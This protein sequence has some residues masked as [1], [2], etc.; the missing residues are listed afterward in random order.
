MILTFAQWNMKFCCHSWCLVPRPS[1]GW[2]VIQ[3]CKNISRWQFS[4]KIHVQNGFDIDGLCLHGLCILSVLYSMFIYSYSQEW[5][6]KSGFTVVYCINC[7]SRNIIWDQNCLD[8]SRSYLEQWS[9][10]RHSIAIADPF[11]IVWSLRGS[12]LLISSACLFLYSCLISSTVSFLFLR[13]LVRM[14][15]YSVILDGYMIFVDVNEMYRI[16]LGGRGTS[17]YE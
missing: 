15:I 9:R 1:T 16:F 8:F 6:L 12:S 4:G 5:S 13:Y 2:H 3:T 10:N 17:L 11:T 14:L 7:T